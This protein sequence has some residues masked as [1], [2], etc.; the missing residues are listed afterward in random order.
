[1]A[2]GIR[3]REGRKGRT[4][5]ASVYSAKDDRKIRRTFT[6][7]AEAKSWRRDA[8][9]QVKDGRFISGKVPTL[10]EAAEA[11]IAGIE[12]G[13]V[14][15][16]E[17]KIYKPSTIRGYRRA[18]RKRVVPE[19]GGMRLNEIQRKDIYR[20]VRGL[21]AEGLGDSTVRNALDPLR[22]LYRVAVDEDEIVAENPTSRLKLPKP[23]GRRDTILDRHQAVRWLDAIRPD[24]RALWATAFYAGLR[25]GEL[26]ALRVE[27]IDLGKSE[28]TVSSTWDEVEGEV[29]PKSDAGT[30]TLPLLAVLRDHLDQHLIATSRTGRD[31]VFGRS[32]SEAFVPS[33]V[34]NRAKT[35][36]KRAKLDPLTL[37][38]A[39]HTFASLLIDAGGN[40]KVIQEFMGHAD[41]RMTYD[42]YGHL[43]DGKRDEMRAQ[44][45]AYLAADVE[46]LLAD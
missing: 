22:A 17:G 5:E 38:D 37:H 21:R 40:A 15:D 3:A 10:A 43:I 4:Y 36:W 9:Q 1:M 31:L 13:A 32:A 28:I 41:I 42:V 16:Q 23:K 8:Q 26:R 24:D 18:L 35:D 6:N 39:R 27:N 46:P 25:R 30:R 11:F 34:G 7:L 2:E 14:R 45:D 29:A 12:T 19:L 33:S 44:V 20:L